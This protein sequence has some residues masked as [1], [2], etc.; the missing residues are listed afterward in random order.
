M[1]VR[2]TVPAS[3]HG[4]TDLPVLRC[5]AGTVGTALTWFADRYPSL[6]QRFLTDSAGIAEIAPWA[7]VSLDQVDVRTLAELATPISAGDHDIE[8][9]GALMGG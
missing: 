9:I 4:L 5:D 8:I 2:F 1:R 7:V 6:R 3:W